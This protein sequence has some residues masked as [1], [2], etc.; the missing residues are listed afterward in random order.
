MCRATR[1]H[2]GWARPVESSTAHASLQHFMWDAV[3]DW[4]YWAGGSL[5]ASLTAALVLHVRTWRSAALA[6]EQPSSAPL[7]SFQ[8]SAGTAPE[9]GLWRGEQLWVL[10][11]EK[12]A[13]LVSCV[14]EQGHL[15][16]ERLHGRLRLPP[17]RPHRVAWKLVQNGV[18]ACSTL[19]CWLG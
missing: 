4:S 9:G 3:R 8:P 5:R 1:V 17:P 6:W 18:I 2:R 11:R 10:A 16:V 19:E 7:C 12:P 13:Q 14:M 15:R